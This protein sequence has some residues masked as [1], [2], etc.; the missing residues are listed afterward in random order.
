M[1]PRQI[2]LRCMEMVAPGG[3]REAIRAFAATLPEDKV[4]VPRELLRD[5]CSYGMVSPIEGVTYGRSHKE[6]IAEAYPILAAA[7][8][9]DSNG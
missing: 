1:T 8:K 4:W 3:D 6:R 2:A 9:G 5:L 7:P